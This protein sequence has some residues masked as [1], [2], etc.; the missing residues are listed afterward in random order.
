VSAFS[1]N[2]YCLGIAAARL[3]SRVQMRLPQGPMDCRF[4]E[5]VLD[6]VCE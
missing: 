6:R 4:I 2:D 5:F 1:Q 3:H